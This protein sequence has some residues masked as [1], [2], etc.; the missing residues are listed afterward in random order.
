MCQLEENQMLPTGEGQFALKAWDGVFELECVETVVTYR[1]TP[2][3]CFVDIPVEGDLPFL[4]SHVRTLRLNSEKIACADMHDR[5]LKDVKGKWWR[6]GKQV[7][8]TVKPREARPL[9]GEVH[10][11]P[12][13]RHMGLYTAA[14]LEQSNKAQVI[15][16]AKQQVLN[17]LIGGLCATRENCLMTSLEGTPRYSLQ[18]LEARLAETVESLTLSWLTTLQ[19]M[20]SAS[21]PVG[22]IGGLIFIMYLGIWVAVALVN[23]G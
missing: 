6:V 4:D 19:W 22:R 11:H 1:P 7:S 12:L 15:P 17:Q 10:G 9:A 5:F 14:E 13:D 20:W 3:E 8:R 23:R 18:N 2:G 21:E 16:R